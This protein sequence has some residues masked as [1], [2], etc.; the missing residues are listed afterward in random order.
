[1]IVVVPCACG[2]EILLHGCEILLRCRETARLQILRQLL[3]RLAQRVVCLRQSRRSG[4]RRLQDG[5]VGLRRG[6][7]PR[8]QVLSELLKLFLECRATRQTLPILDAQ[9][10]RR[11]CDLCTLGM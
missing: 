3:E 5:E 9:E 4:P 6:Q 8:L 2:L 11:Q 7:I 1:M 10:I